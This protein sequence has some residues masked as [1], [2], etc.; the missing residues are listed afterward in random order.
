MTLAYTGMRVNEMINLRSA[1][2]DLAGGFIA[3]VARGEWT[4]KTHEGRKI[5]IHPELLVELTTLA[6][7]SGRSF[8][9]GERDPVTGRVG[10]KLNDRSLLVTCSRLRYHL[11]LP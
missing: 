8:F 11:A 1:D 3:V 7:G 5:P 4:P 10:A 9:K 6:G 2:G